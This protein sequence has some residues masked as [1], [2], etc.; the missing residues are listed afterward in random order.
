M[1]TTLAL[2]SPEAYRSGEFTA[3]RPRV[4]HVPF[5]YFPEPVGG[6][7]VYVQALAQ[8]LCEIGYDNVVAAPAAKADSAVIDGIP[9]YRFAVS[10]QQD[11]A[12]A[13]GSPDLAAAAGFRE[14]IARLRPAVV[15][16]HARTAAVSELLIDIA[17]ATGARVVFTYHTP[18][19]SCARG[20]MLLHGEE[21][22]DGT[23]ERRRCLTCVLTGRGLSPMSSTL[24]AGL[25]ATLVDG[26][27]GWRRLP[28]AVSALRTPGLLAE[29]LTRA[30]R[31]LSKA[32]RIVAVCDWVAEV[33]RRNGVL[34][35][36]LSVSRQGVA[37]VETVAR[38]AARQDGGPIRIAWLGRLDRTKGVDLLMEAASR[39][40]D[41]PIR[42]DLYPVRQ[43]G[44]DRDLAE[45]EAAA[46]SD[47]RIAIK[48]TVGPNRVQEIMAQY[49]MI[50]VPSRW[51]ETGPLVV[52][53]A[54]AAGVP[55]LGAR[56][57]GIAELVR[58]GIDGLLFT[59]GDASALAEVLLRLQREPQL[60]EALKAGVRP[61][62]TM[63][64]AAEDMARIYTE[65]GVPGAGGLTAAAT[66][67]GAADS[68]P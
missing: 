40:P 32:D 59:P 61:P 49:D 52:L 37:A 35:D 24:I 20:T 3:A 68:R 34:E 46:R 48:E 47:P 22:C 13:Y 27:A 9:V 44:S 45:I 65:L 36:R 18:T 16:L 55:V 30:R 66:A 8:H 2:V 43:A 7:E 31:T 1:L 15:H 25:P 39:L 29:G 56:R 4:L 60:L 67:T 6:T 17:H 38:R 53:E 42:V 33:L 11:I 19:V 10:K 23:I 5:T 41:T 58:E 21:P 64:H 14:V 62:R 51:L 26:M 28:R 63:R 54:F 57:G 12:H 50:A